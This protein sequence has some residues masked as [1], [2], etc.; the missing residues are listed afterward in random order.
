MNKTLPL[1]LLIAATSAS[2]AGLN[3]TDT[4]FLAKAV[5][6]NNFE[7]EAAKLAL[8][9]SR[10]ETNRAFARQMIADHTKLGA[11]V[12]AA[13]A[14]A[15]P[16]MKLPMTVTYKQWDMLKALKAS[17]RGFDRMYRTQMIGSHR[18]T[19]A[20]FNQYSQSR[21]A[22]AGLRRVVA[23]AKPVVHMHWDHAFNLAQ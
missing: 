21:Y 20:L 5:R 17:G 13:V 4:G 8:Q 11:Q 6:G 22:N 19:Y 2:A 18:E 23:G 15:D 14:Q 12:K 10:S 3:A 16:G 1:V 7:I 9:M